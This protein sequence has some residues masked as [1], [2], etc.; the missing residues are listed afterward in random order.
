MSVRLDAES[1]PPHAQHAISGVRPSVPAKKGSD[2]PLASGKRV[3][4][5]GPAAP[6]AHE[7]EEEKL[8]QLNTS[9]L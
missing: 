1:P 8:S 6:S 5:R 3:E 4:K 9:S 7:F 2:K